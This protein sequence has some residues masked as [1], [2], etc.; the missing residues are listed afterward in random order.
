MGNFHNEILIFSEN[1]NVY[2][3]KSKIGTWKHIGV[4]LTMFIN[5]YSESLVVSNFTDDRV[6]WYAIP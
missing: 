4:S 2:I 5:K 1:N 3:K 6:D